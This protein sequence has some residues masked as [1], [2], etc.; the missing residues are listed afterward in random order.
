MCG[1]AGIWAGPDTREDPGRIAK[2]MSDAL[3]HRGPD[4]EGIWTCPS[5]QLALG[6]RR[7]AIVDLSEAGHQPMVSAS[8]RFVITYNGEVYNFRRLQG[9]LSALGHRFRGHSDTEVILAAIEQWGL[10]A[11]LARFIGMFAFALWD[12]HHEEFHLVR[13]RVGKKPLYYGEFQ[14]ALA[15]ASELKA[16]RTLCDRP[17]EVDRAALTQFLRFQY[18]PSPRSIYEGVSKVAPGERISYRRTASGTLVQEKLRYWSPLEVFAANSESEFRGT[19][20]DAEHELEALL[21]DAVGL[22]MIS[23]VPLGAFLSGGIDSSLV[24]A[25]MQRLSKAPVRT[26]S[27]GFSSEAF[28]ES[29][30]AASVAEHLRTEHVELVVDGRMALD[31]VPQ[32]PHMYDEPFGDSSQIPTFLVAK[33]A[34]EH[35]TVA[36]SG[37]GGDELFWGYNRYLWWRELWPVLAKTPFALRRFVAQWVLRHDSQQ[38]DAWLGAATCLLPRARRPKAPGMLAR[39]AAETML[40]NGPEALY[41]RLVSHW[42]EPE[43]I[44][45][46]GSE[47]ETVLNAQWPRGTDAGTAHMSVLDMLTYLPDDILVKVDRATMATSLESRCPLLDHRL[48]EF[49]ARLP[50][51]FKISDGKGKAILRSILYRHVPQNL[52]DRPKTGFGIPLAEWLRGPLRDWAESLLSEQRLR[53]EGYFEVEAV[54]HAWSRFQSRREDLHYQ[55]WTLLMFQSWRDAWH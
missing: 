48:L 52:V 35:V 23:D 41:L 54:R 42:R 11:A 17:F 7:L 55:L 14:G 29:R 6:H 45:I 39:K 40:A 44:V 34:R 38:L 27:I 32:L 1:I 37:D 5:Q 46:G 18:V 16:L 21:E 47:P 13:D 3:R 26:F 36:L 51:Q 15:F 33:L 9:E 12:G 31:V 49:A 25:F 43:A 10:D 28:D 20:A 24:V 53:D 50:A 30:H 4:G 2:R 22:R 8:G 19:R